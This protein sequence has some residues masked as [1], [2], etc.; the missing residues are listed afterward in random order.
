VKGQLLSGGVNNEVVMLHILRRIEELKR[1]T[2]RGEDGDIGRLREVYFDDAAWTVR[3]LVINT[4]IWLTG[5]IVLITPDVLGPL[6][7]KEKILPVKLTREQ[8]ETSPAVGEKKPISRQQEAEY[9]RHYSWLPYWR[10]GSL[11]ASA[12]PLEAKSEE[13]VDSHLRT[14]AEVT[15]YQI[16]ARDGEIGYV[17]DFIVDDKDWVV[18]YLEIS[19]HYWWFGKKILIAPAWIGEMNWQERK[20]HVDLLREAI[21]SAPEYD[22][23]EVICRDYEVTLYTHYGRSQYWNKKYGEC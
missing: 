13:K 10:G 20:V 2:F 21:R 9:H 15:G 11:G 19:T 3:Y 6:N 14:S 17:E 23:N 16:E 8:I 7:E 22:E 5:R 1:Y 18:R 12:Q 4:G